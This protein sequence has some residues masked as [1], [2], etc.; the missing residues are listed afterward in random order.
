MLR[1]NEYSADRQS[2]RQFTGLERV[3]AYVFDASGLI[4][5]DAVPG[6]AGYVRLIRDELIR[7]IEHARGIVDDCMCAMDA[8]C[9]GCLRT[10]RNQAHHDELVRGEALETLNG[11]LAHLPG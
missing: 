3:H 7:L 4:I 6:G 10:Y 11:L 5:F 2:E 8:S 9:Y 1:W